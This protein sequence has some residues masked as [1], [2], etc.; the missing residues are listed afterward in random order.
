MM[1]DCWKCLDSCPCL[2][3]ARFNAMARAEANRRAEAYLQER[4]EGCD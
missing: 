1:C 2:C 3:H 4:G